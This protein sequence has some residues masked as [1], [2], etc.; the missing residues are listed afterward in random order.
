MGRLRSR[1]L[2]AIFL[3]PR[4]ASS[5]QRHRPDLLA[6]AGLE[7]LKFLYVRARLLEAHQRLVALQADELALFDVPASYHINPS[8]GALAAWYPA[9]DD[10]TQ[11]W[12]SNAYFV[13]L[14]V[15]PP[16][17]SICALFGVGFQRLGSVLLLASHCLL[18]DVADFR[19]YLNLFFVLALSPGIISTPDSLKSAQQPRQKRRLA[20]VWSLLLSV[21][22]VLAVIY[23]LV[24][25]EATVQGFV[26]APRQ[27]LQQLLLSWNSRSTLSAFIYGVLGCALLSLLKTAAQLWRGEH[28]LGVKR[29]KLVLE[30]VTAALFTAV[31]VSLF[32]QQLILSL[33]HPQKAFF[34]ESTVDELNKSL[35]GIYGQDSLKAWVPG[36]W[37]KAQK[38]ASLGAPV[39]HF[40][41][42][43]TRVNSDK[44]GIWREVNF[45]GKVGSLTKPAAAVGFEASR[46]TYLLGRSAS[47]ANELPLPLLVGLIKFRKHRETFGGRFSLQLF[48][49]DLANYNIK[50]LEQVEVRL[51][52]VKKSHYKRCRAGHSGRYWTR[53]EDAS[54]AHF[55]ID[56]RNELALQQTVEQSLGSKVNFGP[57]DQAPSPL[58]ALNKLLGLL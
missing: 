28:Y 29:P 53:A 42:Y 23:L 34:R 58:R 39:Y 24:D 15:L 44:P 52:R 4:S 45:K 2:L 32:A 54:F 31:F 41:G 48:S 47:E 3:I 43:L 40:E 17:T 35:Q 37:A 6:A 25:F 22:S 14:V 20:A 55:D 33:G 38:A 12:A 5:Q 19:F 18:D 30:L 21:L 46:L 56:A 51:L 50:S 57:A 11:R 10:R 13:A 1:R 7:L 49:A 26:L 36:D 8:G 9:W 27:D 16:L